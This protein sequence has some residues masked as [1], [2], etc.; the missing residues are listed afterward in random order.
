MLALDLDR[1][2]DNRI[3]DTFKG[4]D[5]V[6]EQVQNHLL[7]SV[8]LGADRQAGSGAA[9]FED[10]PLFPQPAGHQQQRT[11][12]GTVDTHGQGLGPCLARKGA[13]FIGDD[14]DTFGQPVDIGQ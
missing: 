9:T 2:R 12:D 13:E 10:N 4:L 7:Q 5:C 1:Q 8:T 14:P 3:S 6:L 11:V